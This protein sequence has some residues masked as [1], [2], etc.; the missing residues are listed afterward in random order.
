MRRLIWLAYLERRRRERFARCR[1]HVV[2]QGVGQVVGVRVKEVFGEVDEL[3][4][5]QVLR[6]SCLPVT[7]RRK[8]YAKRYVLFFIFRNK[9]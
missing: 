4:Q 8:I 1:C 5:A 7:I 9:K 6:L 2:L 3:K